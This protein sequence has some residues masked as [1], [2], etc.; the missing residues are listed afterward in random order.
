MDNIHLKKI[1]SSDLGEITL[2]VGDPAR[3]E[4]ISSN[5]DNTKLIVDNRE[6]ILV[7]GLWNDRK[8]SICSTG[9]GVGSTEIAIIELIQSGAKQLVR[10]GG[11]G[12]WKEELAPGELMLN[13][14]MVRDPG[15]L[16]QYVSD[17]YPAAADPNLL[18]KIKTQAETSGF[19]VHTGIGMTTQSYYLGQGREHRMKNG[20]QPDNAFMNYWQERHVINCEME[21]AVLFLLASLYQIP[22][23]NC[24]VVHVNRINE[25]WVSDEDYKELHQRAAEMVLNACQ[26]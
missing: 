12:A 10:L 24:L 1:K 16:A 9:I 14:A 8:V 5:W 25:Q 22:A 2:L 11:C 19:R 15:M 18:Y 20:P 21:T 13:H 6:F 3:V 26:A 23:A 4:L 7:S 17:V